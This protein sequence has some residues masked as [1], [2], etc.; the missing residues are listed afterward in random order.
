MKLILA[1]LTLLASL[2]GQLGDRVATGGAQ[3]FFR[4]GSGK[5]SEAPCIQQVS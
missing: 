5:N 3:R 2:A 1:L 4:P